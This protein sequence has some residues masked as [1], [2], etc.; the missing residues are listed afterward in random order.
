MN[1]P[2][3][4]S[5][6]GERELTGKDDSSFLPP[7]VRSLFPALKDNIHLD[8]GEIVIDKDGNMEMPGIS[9]GMSADGCERMGSS[10]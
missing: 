10:R 9:G 7:E 4:D 5:L 6:P 8:Y 2:G 3:D 1:G